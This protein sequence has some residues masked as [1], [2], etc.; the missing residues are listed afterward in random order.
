MKDIN[1]MVTRKMIKTQTM[2]NEPLRTTE[3][4]A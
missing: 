4:Q 1:T 3:E 2:V